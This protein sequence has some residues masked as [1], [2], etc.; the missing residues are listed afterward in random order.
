MPDRT[1]TRPGSCPTHGTVRAERQMPR[2]GWPYAVY[3]IRRLLAARRPYR[4]PQ[5]NAPVAG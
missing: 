1:E 5:C 2:P 4:C 3:A